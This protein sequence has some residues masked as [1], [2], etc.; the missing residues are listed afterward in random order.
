MATILI[1]GGTG[2][3]GKSLSKFLVSKQ[4]QV[5]ILTRHPRTGSAGISYAAW[6]PANKTIDI[7]ALQKADYIINLAGAGVAD[8]RWTKKRKQEII[9]SRVQSGG[10]LVKTL[11]ENTNKVKAVI[12]MSGIGWYGEDETRK[13][14][15]PYFKEGDPADEGFLG[16]TCVKW[17]NAIK[18]VTALNKRLV[19]FRTGVVLSNE[20][21][22]L[23]E[24]KKPVRAGLATLLGGGDQVVSWIHIDD[25]CRLFLY[26]I[27]NENMQGEYNAVSPQPVTNKNLMMTLAQKIKGRFYIPI[28]VPSFV[29]KLALG[30]L[31]VEVLKS[32]KVSCEK[33]INTGFQFLYP[34]LDV[35]LDELLKK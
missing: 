17:E 25:M 22:A 10:L 33:I 13:A 6:D 24:F 7:D 2:T 9:D 19:I 35:A 27:E 26:A 11:Q 3:I 8:K 18:P 23:V 31:S 15:A 5:L 32:T 16:A 1:T 14:S 12:S 4:H 20:G 29:L 34:S 28:Y 21:G 30:E